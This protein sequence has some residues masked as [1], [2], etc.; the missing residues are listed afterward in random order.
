MKVKGQSDTL[1]KTGTIADGEMKFTSCKFCVTSNESSCT[2]KP[3]RWA[4]AVADTNL[5]DIICQNFA[6][7]GK[8]SQRN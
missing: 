5:T 8:S 1:I 2:D 7:T 4:G 6:H 3:T